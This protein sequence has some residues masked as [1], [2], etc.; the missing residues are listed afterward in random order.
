MKNPRLAAEV[1]EAIPVSVQAALLPVIK[2]SF[3]I[4]SREGQTYH[5]ALE[6]HSCTCADWEPRRDLPERHPGKCCKHVAHAFSRTGKVFEPWFQALLDDCFAHARGTNPSLNWLLVEV[7]K[8]H[9]L[10]GGGAVAWCQVYAPGESGYESFTF[11]T[12][13]NRW[14]YDVAP[15]RAP[16]IE[17]VIRENFRIG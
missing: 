15:S 16:V 8:K 9:A 17:R 14:S 3:E 4:P 7:A 6:A 5:V 2:T 12:D 10:L 13:R 11:N 1:D